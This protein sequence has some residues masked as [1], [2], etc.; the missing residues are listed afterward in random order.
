MGLESEPGA[1]MRIGCSQWA[2]IPTDRVDDKIT[3]Q[4]NLRVEVPEEQ[5]AGWPRLT[6]AARRQR[7]NRKDL[8]LPRF[9]ITYTNR[10]ASRYPQTGVCVVPGALGAINAGTSL[11]HQLRIVF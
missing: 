1:G 7:A 11:G 6:R 8:R 9:H 5:M 4:M 10:A 3:S 2:S